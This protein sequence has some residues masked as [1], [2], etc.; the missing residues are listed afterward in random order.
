MHGMMTCTCSSCVETR[1]CVSKGNIT[2]LNSMKHECVVKENACKDYDI[3]N[4][5]SLYNAVWAISVGLARKKGNAVPYCP[6]GRFA[7]LAWWIFTMIMLSMYTANLAAS[8]TLKQFDIG[9]RSITDLLKQDELEWG[10][11]PSSH[12]EVIMQYSADADYR[13]IAKYGKSVPNVTEG[14]R[15]A[16]QGDYVFIHESPVLK[17]HAQGDCEIHFITNQFQ[18]FEYA[19]GLPKDAPYADLINNKL[20]QYREF[21]E[22]TLLW[23]KW[24]QL[25]KNCDSHERKISLDVDS[26]GGVFYTLLMALAISLVIVILEFLYVTVLDSCE[27][28]QRNDSGNV[29]SD[30]LDQDDVLVHQDS[31]IEQTENMWIS[32]LW[33]ALLLRCKLSY[34]DIVTHWWSIG[35]FK[36]NK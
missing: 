1:A 34:K 31:K 36:R 24:V 11:L 10:S 4:E 13:K 20:L 21:G 27:V 32:L 25:D 19:F 14:I 6:S 3:L 15:R 26:M 22:V 30:N 16:K 9:I 29:V 35:S 33:D 7:I 17:H 8:F 2:L 28:E 23:D 18:T 12:P 5:L